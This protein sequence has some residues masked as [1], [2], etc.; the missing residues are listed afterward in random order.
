MTEPR[1]EKWMFDEEMLYKILKHR[2]DPYVYTDLRN[3]FQSEIERN[4]KEFAEEVRT[5]VYRRYDMRG[6]DMATQIAAKAAL[7]TEIDFNLK[8]NV[9]LEA[10]GIKP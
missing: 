5:N 10:R 7:S 6:T 2:F 3:L 9:A 1:R 4:L 8:I